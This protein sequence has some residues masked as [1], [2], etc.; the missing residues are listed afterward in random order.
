MYSQT[1]YISSRKR[2]QWLRSSHVDGAGHY[3]L[4]YLIGYKLFKWRF[5]MWTTVAVVDEWIYQSHEEGQK[6]VK[7]LYNRRKQIV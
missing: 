2:I 1:W 4:Q 7:L 3:A 6:A 5:R